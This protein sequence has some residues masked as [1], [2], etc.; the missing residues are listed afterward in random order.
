MASADLRGVFSDLERIHARLRAAVDLRMRRA[1]GLPL[2]LFEPMIVIAETGHCRVHD[3]ATV[4]G[5][6]AGA[7]SKLVDRLEAAGYCRRLRNPGDR[8]SS[9]LRLTAAGRQACA[10]AARVLDEELDRLF[11]QSLS[12]RQL[13]HLAA[14]LRQ[15]RSGLG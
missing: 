4:L 13:S 12:E 10:D 14:T 7:S 8:R 6:S 9:L 5:V 3:L 2:T 11:G 15:L 1:C